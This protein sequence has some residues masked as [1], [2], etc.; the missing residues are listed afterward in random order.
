M[1]KISR[2][3]II[4][5]F[6]CIYILTN[7]S[8]VIGSELDDIYKQ[9]EQI[10][11]KIKETEDKIKQKENERRKTLAELQ[12]LSVSMEK[13]SE[14]IETLVQELAAAEEHLVNAQREINDKEAEVSA[15]SLILGNRLKQIYQQGDINYL[16]IIFQSTSITDFLTRFEFLQKITNNDLNLLAALSEERTILENKRINLENIKVHLAALKSTQEKKHQQMQIASAKRQDL[17]KQIESQKEAYE[18][19]LDELADQ[20]EQIA[21]EIRKLQS[22]GGVRPGWLQ[23]PTPGYYRITSPYGMRFHP[24]L[25]EQRFHTGVDIAA[26]YGSNAIAAANGTVIY[27]GWR[28][29]YGNTIIVDHGGGMATMYPHLSK[30]LVKVGDYVKQNQAVGKVGT[31][32]WSTGPHIHFEVRLDGDHVNPMPYLRK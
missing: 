25:K 29:G 31:S 17:V 18:Q 27:T 28:G 2:T 32:G 10:D 11:S 13:T 24:I 22:A 7:V 15:R 12:S 19:M 9:Q 3:I 26:P 20:S 6:I 21:A 1:S 5:I 14:E 23:W 16:E 30:Y 4:F 8:P